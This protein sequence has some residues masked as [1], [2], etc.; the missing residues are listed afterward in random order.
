ML[1]A[2]QCCLQLIVQ[3]QGA[4][5]QPGATRAYTIYIYSLLGGFF[6]FWMV[7]KAKIV[8]EPLE[9]GFGLTLGNALRRVLLSSLQGGAVTSIKIDGVLIEKVNADT[10]KFCQN[11]LDT[12]ITTWA[13]ENDISQKYYI[14]RDYVIGHHLRTENFMVEDFFADYTSEYDKEREDNYILPIYDKGVTYA[15]GRH[16]YNANLSQ[17]ELNINAI[18]N[19]F[20]KRCFIVNI[21]EG[22]SLVKYHFGRGRIKLVS[23]SIQINFDNIKC[24]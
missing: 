15:D 23:I 12:K 14:I 22:Y 19:F 18:K 3:R 2:G 17:T 20:E 5:S 24:L 16:S 4:S 10:E 9:R 6:Y 8:V 1:K 13:K 21:E 11:L 7:N